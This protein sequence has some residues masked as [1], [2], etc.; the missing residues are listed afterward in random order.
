MGAGE[1]RGG[2]SSTQAIAGLSD[3]STAGHC[4]TEPPQKARTGAAQ[5]GA[6]WHS[7]G[8]ARALTGIQRV[9]LVAHGRRTHAQHSTAQHA[10]CL[11]SRAFSASYSLRMA[12]AA[13]HH[14]GTPWSSPSI[15]R[16]QSSYSISSISSPKR[17]EM[18]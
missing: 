11:H 4:R 7:T 13:R 18:A 10:V 16:F 6:A 5:R 14:E 12:K 9:V 1:C 2:S 15:G 8:D 3:P 17:A